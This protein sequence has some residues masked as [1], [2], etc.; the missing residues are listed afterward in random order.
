[1]TAVASAKKL[2]K[3]DSKR[4]LSTMDG[5]RKIAAF[6]KKQTIFVQGDPS[7]AVCYTKRHRRPRSGKRVDYT[8]RTMA[9][10]KQL[11]QAAKLKAKAA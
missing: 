1:M 8:A 6:A 3:F 4:F 11:E 5:G 7:D 10:V 9:A 2:I